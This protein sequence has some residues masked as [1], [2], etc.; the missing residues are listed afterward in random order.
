MHVLKDQNLAESP[1]V[2]N[3]LH[4]LRKHLGPF[5]IA[6]EGKDRAWELVAVLFRRGSE[7]RVSIA[8]RPVGEEIIRHPVETEGLLAD[9]LLA[10]TISSEHPAI[11]AIATKAT[12]LSRTIST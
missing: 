8:M 5:T 12:A 1:A 10:S 2:E 7:Y 4:D 3:I 6:I 11:A 9:E